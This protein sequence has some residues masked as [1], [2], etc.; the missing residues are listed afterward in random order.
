[1]AASITLTT[2]WNKSD[3]YFASIN[4]AILSEI[5]DANIISISNSIQSYS[6]LQAGF[7]L[8]AVY[9]YFP[10]GTVHIIGV[11]SEDGKNTAHCVVKYQGQY[12]IGNDNGIFALL[13]SETPEAIIHLKSEGKYPGSSFPELTVFAQ[14]AIYIING[15][16]I[17][18]LGETVNSVKQA[19]GFVPVIEE[20]RISG[21]VIYIDSY[22]NAITNI[23]NKIWNEHIGNNNFALFINNMNNKITKI[24]HNYSDVEKGNL[25]AI[26]N[27]LG[28]LEIAQRES[29]VS[30]MLKLDTNSEIFVETFVSDNNLFT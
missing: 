20:N 2:D 6:I 8:R 18:D 5:P 21:K 3:Y 1:M 22:G 4:A 28:L 30:Q 26:F 23:S 25:V 14:V 9:K 29:N 19:S 13:F 15:G 24:H 27:S 10:T 17:D 11:K 7:V 16:N 12:F